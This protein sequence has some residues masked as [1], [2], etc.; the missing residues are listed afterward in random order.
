MYWLIAVIAI[1]FVI[2]LI[3]KAFSNSVKQSAVQNA[4]LA[5]YTYGTL[6]DI[7]KETVREKTI[8]IM[9][10]G[11]LAEEDFDDMCEILKYSFYGLAFAELNIP[12]VL[13]SEQWHY[14]KNP[15]MALSNCER[16]IKVIKHHLA[17]KH[18]IQMDVEYKIPLFGPF[19]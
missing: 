4:F 17:S 19:K 8:Q 15:Y 7:G 2:F 18:N 16:Q 13:K 14:V 10:R 6:D 3:A 9:L 1:L 11:G 12:P 5:K